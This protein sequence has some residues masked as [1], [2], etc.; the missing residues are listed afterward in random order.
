M[1]ANV[2]KGFVPDYVFHIVEKTTNKKV[3][4]IDI[5][6][7]YSKGLYFGGHI[8]YTVYEEYRGNNFAL[9]ACRLIKEVALHHKMDRLYVTCSPDNIASRRT[10]EKLGLELLE[11]VDL[12]IDNDMYLEGERLKCIFL[13]ELQ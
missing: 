10:C 11:I 2:E 12:P 3:G 8:G 4:F 7:G 6:I 5:R 13:W 1:P 9:K